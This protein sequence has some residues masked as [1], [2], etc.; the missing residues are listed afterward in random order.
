MLDIIVLMKS[1]EEKKIALVLGIKVT[2]FFSLVEVEVYT[3]CS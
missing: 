3:V 2:I 1:K